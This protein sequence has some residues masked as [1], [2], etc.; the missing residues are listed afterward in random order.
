MD[1]ERFM[2]LED[3]EVMTVSL[4]VAEEKVL[5][6]NRVDILPILESQFY[7]RKRRMGMEM[8][9]QSVFFQEAQDF[10]DSTVSCHRLR[11][12]A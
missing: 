5:A 11:L 4:M 3:H 7:G 10:I 12:F 2:T 8:I 6:M 9:L 1:I